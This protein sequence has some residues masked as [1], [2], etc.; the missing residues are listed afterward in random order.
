[1]NQ[2]LASTLFAGTL[3]VGLAAQTVHVVGPGGFATIQ[4]AVAAAAPDDIVHVQP[5]TYFS[6]TVPKSLRIR[7]LGPV[8]LGTSVFQPGHVIV[9]APVGATVDLVGFDM[10]S[11]TVT[12]GRA[13]LDA[14]TV[15]NGA[16]VQNASL[17]LQASHLLGATA[18]L[19]TQADV[20][21]VQS[22]FLGP[23]SFL[24]PGPLVDLVGSRFHAS[25]CTVAPFP[26]PQTSVETNLRV[27]NGSRAWIADSHISGTAVGHCPLQVSV[28]SEV[29]VDRT[30][31]AATP[32]CAQPTPGPLLGVQRSSPLLVGQT[33]Q[34][35]F[36]AEPGAFVLLFASSYL[37]KTDFGPLLE[38]PSWLDDQHSFAVT[39]LLADAA[40][41]AP[42]S[43]PIPSSPAVVDL[44]LW[45]KGIS[46]FGLPLQASPPVGGIVR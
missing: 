26:F 7:A 14:C 34:L 17:H 30:T 11:L 22:S 38:Q 20:T 10:M 21:A 23:N 45:I 13:S 43:F 2:R 44:T 33:F 32:G 9:Q 40:G 1:M 28:D 5:G 46:A 37:G 35:E 4:Q 25:F 6:F 27:T 18:L 39:V 31:Y 12:S 8:T 42:V 3:A 36:K 19:A 29:R 41:S 15:R 16:V 24:V